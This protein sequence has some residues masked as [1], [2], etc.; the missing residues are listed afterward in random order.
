M[1]NEKVIIVLIVCVCLILIIVIVSAV[2]FYFCCGP[3]SKRK[4]RNQNFNNLPAVA[5]DSSNSQSLRSQ[6]E[7]QSPK[8][9]PKVGSSRL[10]MTKPYMQASGPNDAYYELKNGVRKNPVLMRDILSMPNVTNAQGRYV[11]EGNLR[12]YH[13]QQI[14]DMM[15]NY[16]EPRAYYNDGF[17]LSHA[18]LPYRNS[19][20]LL[21]T[22]GA[23]P[24]EYVSDNEP[25]QPV[26]RNFSHRLPDD[27]VQ[28]PTRSYPYENAALS[29]YNNE[30]TRS[31][32]R[33]N[34][35]KSFSVKSGSSK[36]SL[37]N[38]GSSRTGSLLSRKS[39]NNSPRLAKSTTSTVISEHNSSELLFPPSHSGLDNSNNDLS[40][41]A[42]V[43]PL[44]DLEFDAECSVS[45]P[46][47]TDNVEIYAQE[48]SVD[49]Q[50]C[51]ESISDVTE[52]ETKG[53]KVTTQ[54]FE[55]L[56]SYLSDD[57]ADKQK[58]T[59]SQN[60]TT[61]A[62]EFLDNYL[63]DDE[64]EKQKDNTYESPR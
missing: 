64:V 35:S 44:L 25:N 60:V 7:E 47:Q 59:I 10:W 14:P 54:A 3:R 31:L 48:K 40:I 30:L 34:I 50:S 57:D 42:K 12:M 37:K 28:R 55:F 19:A 38:K 16:R 6:R 56:D 36:S 49:E 23:Y 62:F 26:L 8:P 20:R 11:Y 15:G 58:D 41:H 32:Q 24:T 17:I 39:Q 63:S 33:S 51:I 53:Q 4:R 18:G 21:K 9:M 1:E 52:S 61:Q 29:G 13:S 5:T 22:N 46:D 2:I 27:K 43:N 45:N